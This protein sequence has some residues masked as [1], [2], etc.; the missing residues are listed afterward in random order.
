MGSNVAVM[1]T[2]Y[3]QQNVDHLRRNC[4]R[5]NVESSN[6][7]ASSS[8]ANTTLTAG[9]VSCRELDWYKTTE[10]LQ[11]L[12]PNKN[13]TAIFDLIVVIKIF[14]KTLR[15]EIQTYHTPIAL[16]IYFFPEKFH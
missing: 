6:R 8:A 16:N 1:S 11:S 12:F 14:E 3:G 10:T 15:L 2:E 5:N 13:D 7:I 4:E 9:F